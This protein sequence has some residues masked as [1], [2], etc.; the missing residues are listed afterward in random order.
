MNAKGWAL[1]FFVY[2]A[3]RIFGSEI[4]PQNEPRVPKVFLLD[5]EHLA[6]T[7]ER[8][9]G[10]D[11]TF[12]PALKELERQAAKALRAGPFSVVDNLVPASGDKHDYMSQAPYF[13]RNPHTTNGLPYVRRDGERNPEIDK[14]PDHHQMNEMTEAVETLALAWHFTGEEHYAAKAR[15]LIRHW[16]LNPETRMNPNLEHAQAIPGIN[17]GRGI[18]IIESRAFSQV[19]DAV[20]LLGESKSWTAEDQRVLKEWFERFLAWMRESKNGQEEAAAKNNHGTFY[21]IQA[22]SYALFV[23]QNDFAKE[24]LLNAATKRIALQI[25]PDGR[26]P[27]E[28]ARTKAWSYSSGNLAGLM[29]LARLGENVGVDLWNFQTADG[30]SIRAALNYLLPFAVE[31]KSWPHEQLGGFSG[32]GLF[33]LIRRA[34]AKYADVS[35]QT[36]ARQLPEP[37]AQSRERLTRRSLK[38]ATAHKAK[39]LVITGGHGF[40]KEPFLKMF[41]QNPA[42]T[43][44]AAA[45]N[46]T[47]A[48]AWERPDL[49]TYDAVVLY[50]MPAEITETQKAGFLSLFD[51]GIGLV[52][53]HH[54]LVS[55][56]HWPEYESIIGGRYPEADGKNGVVS[57]EAG[58][59]HDVDI[60]VVIA[61]KDHPVTAGLKDFTIHDEIYWGF[62]AAP[63][64]TVLITT[65]H[66][67]SGKPLGWARTEGKSRVVYLQL[68]HDRSAFENSNYRKLVAQ[69][70][71]WV[72]KR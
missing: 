15:E 43:F 59:E 49:L 12:A 65:T 34:A 33:P 57:D 52:V 58:Y 55:Y 68:G 2:I 39:V 23:G 67:K 44:T 27:L 26:Q 36:L 28:L 54:A 1:V 72:A 8:I 62:R 13:W 48:F 56:Q 7:R 35:L 50:D 18:G 32:R 47:N 51:R 31:G 30:R 24:L 53:L 69:S 3:A 45:H 37:E 17:T 25:E 70:I 71:D 66:S 29:S 9:R 64:V 46:R 5:G 63:D 10:G 42:I 61:A 4:A 60:P 11:K 21:D 6:K 40:Q 41:E 16:F 22:A 20:G 19:V 14:F 38:D